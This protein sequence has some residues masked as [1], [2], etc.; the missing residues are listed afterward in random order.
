MKNAVKISFAPLS[1]VDFRHV[2][3]HKTYNF[4]QSVPNFIQLGDEMWE[5][6]AEIPSRLYVTCD[7]PLSDR[8]EIYDCLITLS[9]PT[10]TKIRQTV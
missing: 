3:F 7:Y 5:A 8:H 1:N 9:Q 2:H 4:L 6:R 10:F